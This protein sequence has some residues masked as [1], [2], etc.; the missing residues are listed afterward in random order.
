MEPG[1]ELRVVLDVAHRRERAAGHGGW[2]GVREELRSGALREIVR[3]RR[4]AGRKAAGGAAQCLAQRGRDDV[5]LARHVVVLRG[6][7]ARRVGT[8]PSFACQ[9]LTYV[10]DDSQPTNRASACSGS[11]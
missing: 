11:R 7:P 2:K 1:Y 6:A 9:Q 5:Y 8:S 10:S 3:E 4:G